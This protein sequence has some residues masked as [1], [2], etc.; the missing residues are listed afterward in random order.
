MTSKE[1]NEE[2]YEMKISC[3]VL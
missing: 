2:P 3:T 1:L